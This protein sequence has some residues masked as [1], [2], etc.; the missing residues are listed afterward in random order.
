MAMSDSINVSSDKKIHSY[1]DKQQIN[2]NNYEKNYLLSTKY[3]ESEIELNKLI[4]TNGIK[5]IWCGVFIIILGLISAIFFEG[6][7]KL[8]PIF[9]GMF[10]DIFSGCMIF[11]VNRSSENKQ[12]YFENL[13][14]VE[15]EQRIIDTIHKSE[16]EQF[17]ENMIEKIVNKHCKS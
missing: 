7:S 8:I 16:N 6:I 17:K 2:I 15:H 13:T 14:L 3:H 9:S 12:K 4:I 1:E 10:I 11:L 5:M